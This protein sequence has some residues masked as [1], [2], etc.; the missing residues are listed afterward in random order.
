MTW[1]Y[2]NVSFGTYCWFTVAMITH[3]ADSFMH[4]LC[5]LFKGYPLCRF[6][7]TMVTWKVDK[8]IKWINLTCFLMIPYP[9]TH[10]LLTCFLIFAL[11]L[12]NFSHFSQEISSLVCLYMKWVFKYFKF[13]PHKEQSP[14]FMISAC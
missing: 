12:N 5:R 6:M 9:L 7:A 14:D 3:I 11:D 1:F 13:L 2:M 8:L 10:T 4:W